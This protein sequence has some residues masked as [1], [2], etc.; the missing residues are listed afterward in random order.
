MKIKI[1]IAM[2][3]MLVSFGSGK[4]QAQE[5]SKTQ[6]W[7]ATKSPYVISTF[8]C[9]D[10]NKDELV[11][12]GQV[13]IA[14][15]DDAPDKEP[16]PEV[17]IDCPKIT[18]EKGSLMTS[19]ASLRV[20]GRESIGGFV[21][22]T[23]N[24]SRPGKDGVSAPGFDVERAKPDMP[25]G[26]SVRNGDHASDD[27]FNSHGAEIGVRGNDGGNGADGDKG[28]DGGHGGNAT[29]A[30]RIILYA[31]TYLVGTEVKLT[32]N[33]APGGSGALGGI[34]EKGGKGGDGG[35]GGT[36]GNASYQKS[37]NRGGD[38]GNGGVGG[39]GGQGGIGGNGGNGANGGDLYAIIM[40]KDP[41]N[42]G[43]TPAMFVWE[44]NGGGRGIPT[45]GGPG[46]KKSDGGVRGYGGCG[47]QPKKVGDWVVQPGDR[48]G[49]QGLD[50]RPGPEGRGG[51]MGLWG[52]VGLSGK[53]G[54]YNVG[55]I[56][57]IGRAHV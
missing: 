54:N 3:M 50:G 21:T 42:P 5:P 19:M 15:P 9:T 31:G 51:L 47:G 24:R 29:Q 41:L 11:I 52:Q 45:G 17:V 8:N 40:V 43:T 39:A 18:F 14:H 38:G 36:G 53:G 57:E 28:F 35:D 30:G 6:R 27:P 56:P 34:G 7:D 33:G 48:C 13:V 26:P 49:G 10:N 16:A 23:N 1:T 55:Y 25:K 22:V 12:T 2:C 37:A 32:S 20:I 4:T 44:N 46:A